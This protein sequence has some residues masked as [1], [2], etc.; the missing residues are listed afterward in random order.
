VN[1]RNRRVL[2]V[3]TAI[4]G[5]LAAM[6]AVFADRL[7]LSA[8]GGLSE[9]TLL[10]GA[11]AFLFIGAAVAGRRLPF[12]WMILGRVLLGVL[13]SFLIHL[14][15]RG[16]L[17][18]MTEKTA[19][20][21]HLA[22]GLVTGVSE[23]LDYAPHVLWTRPGQFSVTLDT[24]AVWFYGDASV[25]ADSIM[26]GPGEASVLTW[27]DR[28][29][30]GYNSTQSLILLMMD[31]RN[32]PPPETVLIAAGPSD[33]RAAAETGDPRWPLG[34]AGFLERT[35]SAHDLS[36]NLEGPDL[37]QALVRV[38]SVNQRVLEALGEE[39]GFTGDFVWLP[40]DEPLSLEFP[41]ADSLIHAS[42][43]SSS[44]PE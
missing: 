1:D 20:Q 41:D 8:S 4:P 39:Y 2:R 22:P 5:V 25:N 43:R 29:Q 28:R 42:G 33:L 17:G 37:E 24:C 21:P 44:L 10:L 19:V 23:P 35:G 27:A 6:A 36:M 18:S 40:C 12:C 26:T 32:N 13:A 38:Q 31:L 3:F 15:A 7:G 16:L 34:A 11:F 14:S 30:P 9:G